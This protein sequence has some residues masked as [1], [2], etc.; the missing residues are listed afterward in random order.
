MA[1]RT[2]QAPGSGADA[3][4]GADPGVDADLARREV[5]DDRGHVAAPAPPR[6]ARRVA[7]TWRR[8]ATPTATPQP[9]GPVDDRLPSPV[10]RWLTRAVAP[11]APSSTAAVL[12]MSGRI[13]VG[14]W[15][16]F[17]ARQVLAADR[18]FVWA[19]VARFGP[20]PVLGYDAYAQDEDVA[21]MRWRL[22]GVLPVVTASGEDVRRSAAGRLAGELVLNPGTALAPHVRW[23]AV[24]DRHALARVALGGVEH[25]VTVAVDD[26]GT[27]RSVRLP[28]WG[29]PDGTGS[30]LHEFEARCTGDRAFGGYRLPAHVEAGWDLDAPGGEPFIVFDVDGARFL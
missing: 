20:L 8:L 14:S 13:R 22:A 3:G 18:G 26:D 25:A 27:L 15:R 28:R 10:H 7:A 1:R 6:A 16:P 30:A 12:E 5:R 17:T 29:D 23:E 9:F 11:D 4:E 19:A 24:D 21:E 2:P